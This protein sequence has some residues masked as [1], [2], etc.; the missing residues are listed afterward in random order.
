VESPILRYSGRPIG[1]VQVDGLA[2]FLMKAF[3]EEAKAA[4]VLNYFFLLINH[5]NII[6]R[7]HYRICIVVNEVET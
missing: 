2:A 4:N 5:L 3:C 7:Q 6:K 1:A